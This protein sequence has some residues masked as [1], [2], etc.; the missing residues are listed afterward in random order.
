VVEVIYIETPADHDF[1]AFLA[2]MTPGKAL[3]DRSAMFSKPEKKR[4]R[5]LRQKSK[6]ELE[7]IR[8]SEIY[9]AIRMARAMRE[10]TQKAS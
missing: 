3:R 2:R 1:T 5:F 7:Q 6:L 10:T 8:E 9:I 4:D